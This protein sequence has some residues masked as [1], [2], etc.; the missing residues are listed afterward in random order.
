VRS[1]SILKKLLGVTQLYVGLSRPLLIF[2]S[3]GLCCDSMRP[4]L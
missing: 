1:T 4:A 3:G 2:A